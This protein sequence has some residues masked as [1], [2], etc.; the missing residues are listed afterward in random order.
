MRSLV[1]CDMKIESRESDNFINAT[2]LCKAGGKKVNDWYRLGSTKDLV[3]ELTNN[4]NQVIGDHR[5]VI[6]DIIK[7][8]PNNLR[9]SWIHPDLAVQLAQWVS[10]AFSLQV[11]RWIRELCI[12][13]SVSIDS[14]KSDTEVNE[15]KNKL[16][17][18]EKELSTKNTELVEQTEMLN[19]LHNINEELVTYKK[20][21]EKNEHIYIVSTMQYASQGLFKVG[22]TKKI[23]K[24]NSSHNTTHTIGDKVKVL[25]DFMVNCS[26]T[27]EAIILKKLEGLRPSKDNEFLLCPFDLLRDA[28]D[29][30]VDCDTRENETINSLIDTVFKLKCFSFNTTDWT[31]GLDMSIFGE[32]IVMRIEDNELARFDVTCATEEQKREFLKKCLEAYRQTIQEPLVVWKHFQLSLLQALSIPKSRFK[33]LEWRPFLEEEEANNKELNIKWRETKKT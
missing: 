27:V 13:G 24:R 21:K 11:S 23:K 1:L 8:G 9:G 18:K 2:Q 29:L 16:M 19:R 22:R 31:S 3:L 30:I 32:N 20:L 15:L 6:I 28:V 33:A 26:A 25:A 7:A 10:P 14:K 17:E 4:L 12:A 5:T